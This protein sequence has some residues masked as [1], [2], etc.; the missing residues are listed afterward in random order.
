MSNI[1]RTNNNRIAKNTLL[2]YFR[3]IFNMLVML[4]VSRVVLDA[5]GVE[6]YGIYS[7]VGGLVVVFSVISGSLTAAISRYITYELGNG[8]FEKLVRVFSTSILTQFIISVIVIILAETIG[9]WFL[10]TKMVI[11]TERLVAA[12]WLFQFSVLT[13][14]VN[15][16]NVPYN[17]TIIA[18]ERMSIFAYVAIYESVV[19]LIVAFLL[20]YSPIDQLIWYGLLLMIVSISVRIIYGVYCNC[21]FKECKSK[22]RF[23]LSLMKEM[24][25]FA[26]WNFIGS[27]SGILRDHGGSLLINLFYGPTVNAA[28][29]ISMQ[30]SSAVSSFATNFLVALNPQITKSYASGNKDYMMELIYKGARISFYLLLIV[31]LPILISTPYLLGLWLNIIPDYSVQFVRL[32]LILALA[33]SISHPLVTAMLATG[34]IRNYQIIVG[35]LQTLNL[36]ISYLFLLFGAKPDIVIIVAIVISQLCLTARLYMLK[37]M[38]GLNAFSFVKKVYCNVIIVTIFA[39]SLPLM[40]KDYFSQT[41]LSFLFLSVIVV[42]AT[43]LAI[44]FVGFNE[45]ERKSLRYKLYNLKKRFLRS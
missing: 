41:F 21:N 12:N 4:Y 27:A 33:E 6:D 37:G 36:P 38:I 5:L 42:V 15:L 11:P 20:Y 8:D 13:F 3:M 7:A 31:S 44:Y 16:I 30:V 34:N 9:L 19:K 25:G 1:E 28:R 10:N 2:L 23:D 24:F 22:L 43:V 45:N 29:G 26:G 40:V 18:H 17:A 39:I 32:V 35:G 14:V